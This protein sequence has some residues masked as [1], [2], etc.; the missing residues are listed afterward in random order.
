MITSL[1]P[2]TAFAQARQLL[3]DNPCLTEIGLDIPAWSWTI[4]R[5]GTVIQER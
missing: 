3:V 2:V 1:D 5:D 4:K